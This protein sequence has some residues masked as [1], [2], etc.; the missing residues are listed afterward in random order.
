MDTDEH[1]YKT[2]DSELFTKDRHLSHRKFF[3]LL[4]AFICGE[5]VF[6]PSLAGRLRCRKLA[7]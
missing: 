1:G 4:S 3:L 6:Y 5:Q 7:A 2:E